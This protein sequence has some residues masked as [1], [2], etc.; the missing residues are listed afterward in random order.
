MP[1]YGKGK[2]LGE[3]V[4]SSINYGS[5]RGSF[6]SV[7]GSAGPAIMQYLNNIDPR[8]TPEVKRV[9]AESTHWALWV[10]DDWHLGRE[11]GIDVVFLLC[12]KCGT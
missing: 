12:T 1:L 10:G 4:G 9:A 5:I 11:R 8:H 7:I 6:G 2:N 3:K